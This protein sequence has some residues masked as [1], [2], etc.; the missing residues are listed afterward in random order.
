MFLGRAGAPRPDGLSPGEE[1]PAQ[2]LVGYRLCQ[3]VLDLPTAS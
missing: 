3:M 2:F 1:L